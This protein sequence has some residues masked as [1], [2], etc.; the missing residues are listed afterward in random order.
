MKCSSGM[1]SGSGTCTGLFLPLAIALLLDVVGHGAVG[2]LGPLRC[3]ATYAAPAATLVGA[4]G[5]EAVCCCDV[6]HEVAAVARATTR[7]GPRRSEGVEPVS[8]CFPS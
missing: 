2:L 8:P 1:S 4:D 3:L 7:T 5:S 6:W